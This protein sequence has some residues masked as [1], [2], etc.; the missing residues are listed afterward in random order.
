VAVQKQL[1][2]STLCKFHLQGSCV[3]GA[4]CMH[5]HSP[6]ELQ[7]APDLTSTSLCKDF[8]FYGQCNNRRCRFAHSRKELNISGAFYRTKLCAFQRLGECRSGKS[9][10]FAHTKDDLERA[11]HEASAN[12]AV[13]MR[14]GNVDE[15][16]VNVEYDRSE[17]PPTLDFLYHPEPQNAHEGRLPTSSG[18]DQGKGKEANVS[19]ASPR[20]LRDDNINETPYHEYPHQMHA[21]P[22]VPPTLYVPVHAFVTGP[23]FFLPHGNPNELLYPVPAGQGQGYYRPAD[24]TLPPENAWK[25]GH[26]LYAPSEIGTSRPQYAGQMGH[27]SQIMT[28]L[29]PMEANPGIT[30]AM[31][32]M[33]NG[34]TSYIPTTFAASYSGASS[35]SQVAQTAPPMQTVPPHMG[36][37]PHEGWDAAHSMPVQMG[38]TNAPYG[39]NRGGKQVE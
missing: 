4:N 7:P 34:I 22:L 26:Q 14:P 36:F 23:P 33:G 29:M 13:I 1:F 16:N 20:V 27:Y 8:L 39:Y 10:R 35:S 18:K 24:H 28:T 3:R 9:C 19:H 12:K 21:Q 31:P 6:T 25:I 30:T 37:A 17:A 11:R 2:K 32:T 5:A 38:N 15:E